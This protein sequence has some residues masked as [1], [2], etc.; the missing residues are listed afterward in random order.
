MSHNFLGLSANDCHA[1]AHARWL[2]CCRYA[3]FAFEVTPNDAEGF[4]TLHVFASTSGSVYHDGLG[5]GF[6]R[7][8]FTVGIRINT[9]VFAALTF[10]PAHGGVHA[11]QVNGDSATQSFDTSMPNGPFVHSPRHSPLVV[12]AAD[13]G[14]FAFCGLIHDVQVRSPRVERDH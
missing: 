1:H 12:G 10:S 3:T 6:A 4:A 13:P 14:M 9:W 7:A 11:V 8:D 2:A 5:Q